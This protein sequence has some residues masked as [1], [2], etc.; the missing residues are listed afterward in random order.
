MKDY[1]ANNYK[2]EL[3]G[4]KIITETNTTSTIEQLC[5]LKKFIDS[6]KPELNYEDLIIVSSEFFNDRVKLYA[7]Y[8][9][10][11]IEGMMFVGSTVPSEPKDNFESAEE[12]KLKKA[13]NWLK[14]HR[15][16]DADTILADQ[17]T[18]QARIINN[19]I[20]HPVS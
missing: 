3:A 10:G 12:D 1:L 19:G 13:K 11:N 18:F 14:S 8:I 7:E 9:F 5:Y 17:K 2:E 20:E 16:G 6:R 15:K 4:I